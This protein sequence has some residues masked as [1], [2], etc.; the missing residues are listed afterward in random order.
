MSFDLI[1]DEILAQN[2][3]FPSLAAFHATPLVAP[4]SDWI[5][6]FQNGYH[7]EYARTPGASELI[8]VNDGSTW[9]RASIVPADLV[10][11]LGD[12]MVNL[13][14]IVTGKGVWTPGLAWSG[15]GGSFTIDPATGGDWR[16][17][18]DLVLFR[19]R[20]VA[21]AGVGGAGNLQLTGIPAGLANLNGSMVGFIEVVQDSF[22]FQ[23]PYGASHWRV[24]LEG[25]QTRGPFYY[26]AGANSAKVYV[27]GLTAT[28]VG[29]QSAITLGGTGRFGYIADFEPDP[30]VAGAGRVLM[31]RRQAELTDGM[32]LTNAGWTGTVDL[33]KTQFFAA[34]QSTPLGT[35]DLIRN[36]AFDLR[37]QGTL[38]VA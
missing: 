38:V 19:G 26:D 16:R 36:Q 34:A 12:L 27:T 33:A 6:I 31:V 23:T 17:V 18:G 13:A 25:G 35:I 7:V 28:P 24:R 22:F 14:G 5:R 20:L 1:P 4:G 21:T 15:G 29:D 8:N 32:A 37:L 2:T 3:R 11:L 10:A 30:L 9:K